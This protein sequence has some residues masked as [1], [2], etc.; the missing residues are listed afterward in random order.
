MLGTA[1]LTANRNWP[2]WLISTQ[3][4]AVWRS[5]KGD[6]PIEV[7]P[8]SAATLNDETVPLLAPPWAFETNSWLGLVGR[9][10][11]PNGPGP[12]AAK[13]E[14]GAAVSRPFDPTAK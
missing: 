4:G 10:S 9:N 2:S 1:V 5:A 12:W 7:S 6:C 14:P 8:P 13:G 11:L 3:Q